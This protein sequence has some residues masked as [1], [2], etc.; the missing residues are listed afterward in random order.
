[1][2]HQSLQDANRKF[3]DLFIIIQELIYV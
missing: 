1:L 2:T 3:S